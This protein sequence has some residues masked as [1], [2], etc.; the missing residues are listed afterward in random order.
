VA[1]YNAWIDGNTQ[2]LGIV[3]TPVAQLKSPGVWNPLFRKHGINAAFL[4]YDA[5]VDRFDEAISGLKA[6]ANVRGF[7]ITMPHKVAAVKH[8]DRL[9]PHAAHVGAISMMR[10]ED[11]GS[12]TGDSCEADAFL[13]SLHS[14][15]LEPKGVNAFLV[16]AGGA[17]Q[18]LAW[19]LA[20]AGVSRL[21]IHD[22]DEGKVRQL[23][24]KIRETTGVDAVAGGND[25]SGHDLVVNATP[26]GMKDSDP[27]PTEVGKISA[28]AFLLDMV[29]D[30][31]PSRFLRVASERGL[32]GVHGLRVLQETIPVFAKFMGLG[33]L[34]GN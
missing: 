15:G 16:G 9:A 32:R 22:V 7:M 6:L 2:L 29:V 12:W 4:A 25:P 17:G 31:A 5:P 24:A 18:V 21:T 20:S 10:R 11:D 1:D 34:A 27:L 14:A 19:A 26:M 13:Q 3:G 8:V 23:A 30:P 33:P 28:N